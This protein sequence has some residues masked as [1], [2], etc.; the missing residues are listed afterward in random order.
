[1]EINERGNTA[2]KQ[3]GHLPQTPFGICFHFA[4]LTALMVIAIPTLPRS[5]IVP[6]L[7]WKQP[8]GERIWVPRAPDITV[9]PVP[10]SCWAP[11]TEGH[12][13]DPIS[14][15]LKA[16]GQRGCRVTYLPTLQTFLPLGS[17]SWAEPCTHS[18]SCRQSSRRVLA[19]LPGQQRLSIRLSVCG[20]LSCG[21]ASSSHQPWFLPEETR[22]EASQPHARGAGGRRRQGMPQPCLLLTFAAKGMHGTGLSLLTQGTAPTGHCPMAHPTAP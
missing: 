14:F 1:M 19:I 15:Y 20:F 2:I 13:E 4:F 7:S 18:H 5:P 22:E 10:M 16:Q 17:S 21:S 9:L 11:P 6:R 3:H 8:H 12:M